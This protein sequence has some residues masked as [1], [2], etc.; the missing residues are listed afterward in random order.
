VAKKQISTEQN[1]D[2]TKEVLRLLAETPVQLKKLSIG[3]SDRKL[4]LPLGKGERSFIQCLA[5]LLNCE[6]RSS[7]AI[8][9]ALLAK[10]PV[11]ASIH[12]ERDLGKLLRY[13]LMPFQKLLSNFEFR[14]TVLIHV[15]NSLKEKQWS[16]VIREEGKQRR[17]SVYWKARGLALHE[18]EH[19][20]DL[21][22]K[23]N[24]K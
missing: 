2:N 1:E 12:P 5:H 3:L 6:A 7:E 18:L 22:R 15:L 8:Q 20:Q 16:R 9:L 17:E 11:F 23:L 19:L 14:R 4:H 10:E 21:E 13:D 24:K